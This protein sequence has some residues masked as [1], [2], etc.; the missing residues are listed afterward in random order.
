MTHPVS[1]TARHER[2]LIISI[3]LAGSFVVVEVLGGILTGS[4]ALLADAGHMFTDVGGL[5]LA[6]FAARLALRPATPARTYGSYR[7]EILAALVNAVVLI[8]LSAYILIEAWRRFL[9][10]PDV[11]GGWMLVVGA[12]GLGVNLVSMRILRAG[13]AESL[14]LKGAYFEVL[15][16]MLSSFAVVVAAAVTWLT[17]W[18][19]T[20]PLV[21]AGIGLFILPR[22][23]TL[24]RQAVGVLLEGTPADIDLA[25]LREALSAEP[26]VSGI[27]DL[28]VWSL[29]SGVNAMSAHVVCESLESRDEL[30]D[31]LHR[32]VKEKFQIEH[33]TLQ[34]ERPGWETTETHL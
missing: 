10:P 3:A 30:L 27:H 20:D 23:W 5:A 22:T 24:M 19:F 25:A 33:V 26:G 32:R 11:A 13:A 34:L 28:H 7:A 12:V 6:L 9:N 21:S 2:A 4:L 16:D 31:R 8:G 17:G 18:K 14:N 29:T 15:S 1:A